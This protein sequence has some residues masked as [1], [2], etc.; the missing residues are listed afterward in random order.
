[1]VLKILKIL[2]P[3]IKIQKERTKEGHEKPTFEAHN[4]S[5]KHTYQ[6][7]IGEDQKPMKI[8]QLICLNSY[9]FWEKVV[10]DS[11]MI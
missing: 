3:M 8:G 6:T 11:L 9:F 5:F 2:L 10:F 1:M 4:Y 7:K